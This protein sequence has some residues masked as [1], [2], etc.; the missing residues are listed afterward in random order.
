[1]LASEGFEL[2]AGA[3]VYVVT[4]H[5][6]EDPATIEGPFT[7]GNPHKRTGNFTVK[8]RHESVQFSANGWRRGGYEWGPSMVAYRE[9]D[10]A[11]LRVR[12]ETAYRKQRLRLQILAKNHA[13]FVF[14]HDFPALPALTAQLT[15][16][17]DS[18]EH[19]FDTLQQLN[20]EAAEAKAAAR[21]AR[22]AEKQED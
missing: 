21:A 2:T 10:P 18:L 6:G 1:M 20:Q 8:M 12:T 5:R 17:G 14:P 16:I 7:L 9:N 22:D 11:F 15:A 19:F 13:A 4:H 3:V